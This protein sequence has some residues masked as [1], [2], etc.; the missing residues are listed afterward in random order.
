MVR[1]WEP[2]HG[3]Q[4]GIPGVYWRDRPKPWQVRFTRNKKH[5]YVGSYDRLTKAIEA[6][7]TFIDK[8]SVNAS[9]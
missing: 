8:E 4:Y 6:A 9:V 5:V 7:K 1:K 3:H 2:I